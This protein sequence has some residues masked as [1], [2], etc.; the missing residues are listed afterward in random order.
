MRC[1]GIQQENTGVLIVKKP[2]IA[3]QAVLMKWLE[4]VP[5]AQRLWVLTGAIAFLTG[6]VALQLVHQPMTAQ[7][8]RIR[9]QLEEAEQKLETLRSIAS[10]EKELKRLSSKLLHEGG[11]ETLIQHVTQLA[12]QSGL[13]LLSAQPRPTT[14]AAG[15]YHLVQVDVTARGSFR[16][17]CTFLGALKVQEPF[18]EV[19]RFEAKGIMEG[20]SGG[21]GTLGLEQGAGYRANL[22]EL[23]E[24]AAKVDLLQLMNTHDIQAQITVEGW[25][26]KA[27]S[28]AA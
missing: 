25:T 1:G 20:P 17:L 16:S 18:I 23:S 27:G 4:K 24:A 12:A 26:R 13:T 6:I 8:K 22:G 9:V 2:E 21:E 19:D 11:A 7:Q 3:P 5:A 28:G 10:N 14:M 15:S